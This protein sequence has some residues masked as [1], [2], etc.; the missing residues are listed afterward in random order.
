MIIDAFM[1]FNELELLEIRLN[2]LDSVVDYFVITES[3][4]RHGS[5]ESKPAFIQDNWDIVKPFEHKVKY[6]LLP[7]LDPAYTSSSSGWKRENY[8]RNVLMDYVSEISTNPDE[9]I[10]IVSDAD[11][12]PRAA[13]IKENLPTISKG[14]YRLSLELFFYN[15]NRFVGLSCEGAGFP[16]AGPV[17]HFQ[18]G[19]TAQFDT[20]RISVGLSAIRGT[21]YNQIPNGGWHFSYFGGIDRMRN[22]VSSYAES[23]LD[24]AVTFRGRTDAQ[25]AQDI[26]TG[27]DIYHR[28]IYQPFTWRETNDP[29]LPAH[30]LNNIEKY[31]HFTEDFFKR[32]NGL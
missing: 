20:D 5:S 4:E 11:E 18:R 28:G 15:I 1:F 2:E 16:I 21:G 32:E 6:V 3:L 22:K 8:Q 25:I 9:D 27:E 31:K 30:F 17:S 26:A 23:Y 19:G 7:H 10:L 13:T 12:I 29:K 14:L 24:L